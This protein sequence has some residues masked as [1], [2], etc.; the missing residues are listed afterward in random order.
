MIRAAGL[1]EAR[2]GPAE[3]KLYFHCLRYRP[4][5]LPTTAAA[6]QDFINFFLSAL[7]LLT[8]NF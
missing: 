1:G 2:L 3:P 5:L 8:T 6:A 4:G 7:A